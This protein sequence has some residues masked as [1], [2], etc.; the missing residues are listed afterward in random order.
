MTIGLCVP[1][2]KQRQYTY[3][4]IHGL[5]NQSCKPDIIL[6]I[7]SDG[8]N[9]V[10]SQFK[11]INA[12][13]Y[14][15]NAKDFD[16]GGTRQ[17][18]CDC[19]TSVDII[20][21]LTQDAILARNDSVENLLRCFSDGAVGVAYGR[22]LPRHGSH[23]IEA[24]ARLYNYPKESEVRCKNDISRLGFKTVFISNS[25]AAYRT[26]AL[27]S[28]G[29]FASPT[30]FGEDTCVAAKMIQK[31]WKIAYSAA[32]Q[33]YHSHNLTCMEEFR[34]YFDI[35]VFHAKEHW[36]LEMCGPPSGEGARFVRSELNFLSQSQKNLIPGALCRSVLKWCGYRLGLVNESLPKSMRVSLSNNSTY[37]SKMG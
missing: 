26:E 5:L 18:A 9:I 1:I 2:Y 6:A 21:F 19:L 28:V 31:N 10:E 17:L 22:Q 7:M 3:Q 23:P 32:A 12:V 34:R 27:R 13:V 30:I 4:F 20:I 33:V 15:I 16:H 35:G 25:F 11:Q 24:H 14:N 29:G 8:D 36:L 37:W